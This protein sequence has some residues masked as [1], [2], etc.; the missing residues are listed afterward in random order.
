[1]SCFCGLAFGDRI[2]DVALALRRLLAAEDAPGL[3]AGAGAR[4]G[5]VAGVLTGETELLALDVWL[6]GVSL[7]AEWATSSGDSGVGAGRRGGR[8]P[9]LP[10]V[11]SEVVCT[12]GA[13]VSA[14]RPGAFLLKHFT[15]ALTYRCRAQKLARCASAVAS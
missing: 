2:D 7:P 10:L 8:R 11:F 4:P 14:R 1:M 6:S 3:R 15:D 9:S 12:T 13:G 5:L